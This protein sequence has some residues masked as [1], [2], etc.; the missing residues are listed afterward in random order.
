[1]SNYPTSRLAFSSLP[2]ELDHL[3]HVHKLDIQQVNETNTTII[4]VKI[5]KGIAIVFKLSSSEYPPSSRSSQVEVISADL[6]NLKPVRVTAVN[7]FI[8]EANELVNAVLAA[9]DELSIKTICLDVKDRIRG[10]PFVMQTLDIL[11][12]QQCIFSN[13]ASEATTSGSTKQLKD[14]QVVLGDSQD[15]VH[16]SKFKGIWLKISREVL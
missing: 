14:K 9:D 1:M 12:N 7:E 8:A 2:T 6:A 16:A 10:D 5:T 3:K 15:E 4:E 11:A 13:L